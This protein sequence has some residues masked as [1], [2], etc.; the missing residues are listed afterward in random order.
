MNPSK[1]TKP[2]WSFQYRGPITGANR[3]V[4]IHE[5]KLI[6]AMAVFNTQAKTSGFDTP[7]RATRRAGRPYVFT[8]QGR[9]DVPRLVSN[10]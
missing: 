3:L 4:D 1:T 2:F 7:I 8:F 6:D 10:G 5:D 9:Y